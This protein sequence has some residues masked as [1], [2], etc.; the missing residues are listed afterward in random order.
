MLPIQIWLQLGGAPSQGSGSITYNGF[1]GAS[2]GDGPVPPPE[3]QA[4]SPAI[5]TSA[6][7]LIVTA[8]VP[9]PAISGLMLIGVA[10]I[11]SRRFGRR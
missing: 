9:E 2:A 11:L 4:S 1:W 3:P 7:L 6:T 8:P 5:V 10:A